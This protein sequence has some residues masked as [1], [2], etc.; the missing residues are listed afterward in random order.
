ML[1]RFGELDRIE[2]D[3][4]VPLHELMLLDMESPESEFRSKSQSERNEIAK[5]L[6]KTLVEKA[7]ML[8]EY[9][10]IDITP[11]GELVALPQIIDEY[12]PDLEGKLCRFVVQ[13]AKDVRFL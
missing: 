4:R 8:R 12:T 9:F 5:V 2:L 1:H 10:S 11:S 3:E 7:E 6:V 13:L